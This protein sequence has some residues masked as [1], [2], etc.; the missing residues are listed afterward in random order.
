MMGHVVDGHLQRVL[1]AQHNHG[2]RVAD[3]D[4]VEQLSQL[5]VASR[6]DLGDVAYDLVE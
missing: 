3:E 5:P 1:V 4:Q 2:Q 6:L